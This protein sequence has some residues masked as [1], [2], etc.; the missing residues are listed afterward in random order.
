MKPQK[1]KPLMI[2][3]SNKDI[4]EMF[5]AMET[6]VEPLAKE[7]SELID[8]LREIKNNVA[9]IQQRHWKE[10]EARLL[11][12]GIIDSKDV[13]L[14]VRDGVLY[15]DPKDAHGGLGELLSRLFE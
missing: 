11:R 12:D 8:R 5:S 15:M 14:S 6:E 1:S 13:S 10:I 4:H 9:S 7:G 3:E 2:L